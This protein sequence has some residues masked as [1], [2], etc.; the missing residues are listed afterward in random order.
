MDDD[1]L[2]FILFNAHKG[3]FHF[4]TPLPGLAALEV[5]AV[6]LNAEL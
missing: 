3:Y 2:I 4:V 1:C 5:I 6:V